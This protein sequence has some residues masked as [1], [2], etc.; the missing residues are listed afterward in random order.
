MTDAPAAIKATFAD[1]RPVKTRKLMQLVFEV[2]IE[3]ADAALSA[4][5][6]VPLPDQERWVAIA[7]LDMAAVEKPA[8]PAKE[9]RAFCDLPMPQQ[10][11]LKCN[12]PAFVHWMLDMYADGF[13]AGTTAEEMVRCLCRVD[14]RAKI[15]PCTSAGDRW[16]ALLREYEGVR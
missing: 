2:P 7:R 10:A 5:G 14:S 12:D 1:F 15:L 13:V 6:G 3:Q 16:L 4:L 9:R 11:A 8:D